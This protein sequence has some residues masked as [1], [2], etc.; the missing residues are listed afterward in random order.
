MSRFKKELQKRGIL[1]TASDEDVAR[2]AEYDVDHKL[3]DIT[4]KFIITIIHRSS[5]RYYSSTTERP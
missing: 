1:Y 3:V 5:T 2:G 4:D